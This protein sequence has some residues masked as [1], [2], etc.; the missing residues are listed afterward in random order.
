VYGCLCSASTLTDRLLNQETPLP[1]IIGNKHG[2][3]P[4]QNLAKH[5]HHV[6]RRSVGDLWPSVAATC[7]AHLPYY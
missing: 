6:L 7:S 1:S 5:P 2:L 3:H 4:T